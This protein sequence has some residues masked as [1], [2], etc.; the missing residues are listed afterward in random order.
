MILS[1]SLIILLGL[2][3]NAI[4]LKV[5]IP[6]LIAYMITGL[7][8]GPYVLDMLDTSLMNISSELRKIALIVILLRTGL[9]LVL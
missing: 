1:L 7:I 6:S 8:L 9:T 5:K 3:L 4:L 2:S